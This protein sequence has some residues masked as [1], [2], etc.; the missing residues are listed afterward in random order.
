M[1][2][3]LES[4][5]LIV[6]GFS[7]T[8]ANAQLGGR[9]SYQFLNVPVNS[10]VAGLG[11][12]NVSQ[13]GVDVNLI[14]QNPATLS[15]TL[16]NNLS[17]NYLPYL[18]D[19]NATMVNYAF[20]AGNT[21]LWGVGMRYFNYGTFSGADL[22]GNSTGDFKSKEYVFSV[23]KAHTV[24]HFTLGASLNMAFSQI[25]AYNS[26][27]LLADLGGIFKHPEKDWAIGLVFKN[28]GVPFKKYVKGET[29]D[30]PA[31]VQLGTSFKPEHMPV[32]MSLTAHHL[33]KW[34][35]VYDNPNQKTKVDLNGNVIKERVS[36]GSK[37]LCHFAVGA[38]FLM[39]K[40]FQLRAGYNFLRRKE[41]VEE[42]RSG[43][44]GLSLGGMIRIKYFEFA[45]TRSFYYIGTGTN[46]FTLTTDFNRI[47]KKRIG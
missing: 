17:I 20:N 14:T 39:S 1:T 5:F 21:G 35:I 33:H 2:I 30:L 16:R 31:D 41:L 22:A 36:F 28:L 6:F 44:A 15:D 19:I 9:A 40:N 29:V 32:R 47:L 43:G 24:N 3:K 34:D 46:H 11:G 13:P 25:G 4:L 8:I 7:Y 37:L 26:A 45:Y 27:A 10:R 42:S 12:I 18:A 23:A 38:E